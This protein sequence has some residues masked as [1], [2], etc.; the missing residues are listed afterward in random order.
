MDNTETELFLDRPWDVDPATGAVI[1][2]IPTPAGIGRAV[3]VAYDGGGLY[4][5]DGSNLLYELDCT[6]S[7]LLNGPYAIQHRLWKSRVEG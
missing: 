2:N 4:Y 3:G 6:A 5:V 1:R 7:L